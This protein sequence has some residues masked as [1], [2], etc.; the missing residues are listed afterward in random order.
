M[1]FWIN[2]RDNAL[3]GKKLITSAHAHH[4]SAYSKEKKIFFCKENIRVMNHI[5][6]YLTHIIKIASL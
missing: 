1:T 4:L 5:M 3:L 2:L 6:C